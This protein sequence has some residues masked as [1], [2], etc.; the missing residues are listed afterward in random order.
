M[1]NMPHGDIVGEL[2][3]DSDFTI[4][5]L[6]VDQDTNDTV[7]TIVHDLHPEDECLV[8]LVSNE[9]DGE[10]AMILEF[11][12]PDSYTEEEAKKIKVYKYRINQH[13]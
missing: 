8:K 11:E 13:N 5:D 6:E 12:G 3:Q 4:V 1:T 9:A 10:D 7:F 2:L